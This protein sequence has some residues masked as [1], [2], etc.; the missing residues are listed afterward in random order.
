MRSRRDDRGYVGRG[1]V[2]QVE[3]ALAAAD[4]LA[5]GCVGSVWNATMRVVGERERRALLNQPL[6]LAS[7]VVR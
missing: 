4:V 1:R 6:G 5:A 3:E 2:Q 7:I